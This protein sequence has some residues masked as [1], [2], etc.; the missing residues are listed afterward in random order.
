M[1]VPIKYS[2]P[3]AAG[4]NFLVS[5]G[6]GVIVITPVVSVIYFTALRRVPV[7]DFQN[8]LIPGLSA[9]VMWNIGNWASIYATNILGYTVGFPLAQCALL[10]GAFW[11]IILFKEITGTLR[12]GVFILSALV[13]L[14][15]AVLLTLFGKK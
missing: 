8:L 10:M 4:I 2:P 1:L 11:G 6:I 15:G 3:D 12:I 5:F 13:L 9:G 14:G 7:W